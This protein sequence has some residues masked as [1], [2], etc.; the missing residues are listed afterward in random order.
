MDGGGDG[1][2]EEEEDDEDENEEVGKENVVLMCIKIK[3]NIWKGLIVLDK[4]NV[5]R[6]PYTKFLQESLLQF[7]YSPKKALCSCDFVDIYAG[8]CRLTRK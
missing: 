5:F 6:I 4:L 1:A 8:K 7:S 2:E 3:K